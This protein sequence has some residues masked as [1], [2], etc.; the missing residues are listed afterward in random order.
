MRW[1]LRHLPGPR[2]LLFF[3]NIVPLS[4]HGLH[5][6]RKRWQEDYGDVFVWWR[7]MR[8]PQVTVSDPE[9]ARKVRT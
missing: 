1:K 5:E 2:P 8:S 9:S 6:Q 7:G 4:K 3:G